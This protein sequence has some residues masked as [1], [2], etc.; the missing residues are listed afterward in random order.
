MIEISIVLVILGLLLG[1]GAQMLPMLTKQ[2]K[3]KENRQLVS[4]ART[5]LIGYAMATGR[6][7][8][9]SANTDGVETIGRVNG[10]LPW[11]TLGMRG[12]DPYTKTMFYAVESHLTDTTS[13]LIF[14][15]RLQALA[16][17]IIIPDLYCESDTTPSTRLYMA[18]L[19]LSGG[20]NMRA[21][22]P[23]DDNNNHII[24]PGDI[25]P[26]AS[27]SAV[28]GTDYDDIM[29]AVNINYLYGLN[30]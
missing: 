25:N 18:F 9:A 16:L 24:D 17:R 10:Y 1:L 13:L 5:T 14:K 4:E 19:V 20:E 29:Q 28:V 30:F 23:N 2:N 6:L 12:T 15:A 22:S 21:D 11:A 26:F 27:P 3:L 8:Y 7:P